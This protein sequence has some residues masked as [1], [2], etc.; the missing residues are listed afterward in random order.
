MQTNVA[1]N[2]DYTGD[3]GTDEADGYGGELDHV[4]ND[5]LYFSPRVPNGGRAIESQPLMGNSQNAQW[6]AY[7]DERL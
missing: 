4:S 7:V 6:N 2:A 1:R 3:L 5:S